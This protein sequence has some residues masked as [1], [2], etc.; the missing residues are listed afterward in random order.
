MDEFY[1]IMKNL[2]D[3]ILESLK[4]KWTTSNKERLKELETWLKSKS[5]DDFL[6]SLNKMLDDPKAKVLLIDG[7]GGILGE[8]KF[9][10]EEKEIHPEDLTPTQNEID[11]NKSLDYLLTKPQ[12]V[13]N[14]YK[15]VIVIDKSPVVTFNGKYIIDGHHRW[16]EAVVLRPK[17]NLLCYDYSAKLSPKQ[18]LKAVQGAIAAVMAENDKDKIPSSR[19]HGENMYD[20]N[21]HEIAKYVNSTITQ[22]VCN[23]ITELDDKIDGQEAAIDYIIK[24][25]IKVRDTIKPIENAPDRD[26]MPQTS[27]AGADINDKSTADPDDDGSALNKLVD[28]KIH[29]DAVK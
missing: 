9:I 13:E 15:D 4:K 2:T 25:M 22:A 24:R 18:M 1:R 17:G 20:M 14:D 12:N 26:D 19:T 6:D 11:I 28:G 23:K 10:F 8:T 5:Y 21:D 27:K 29:K 7:F 3:Y 16:I